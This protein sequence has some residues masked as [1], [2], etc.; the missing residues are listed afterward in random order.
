MVVRE[1]KYRIR[2][3]L[4]IDEWG[5]VKKGDI[6]TYYFNLLDESNGLARF[7]IDK[8]WEILSCDEFTGLIDIN[9][10]DVYTGDIIKSTHY[11]HHEK[12]LILFQ[13]VIFGESGYEAKCLVNREDLAFETT[14]QHC[15]LYWV[16]KIEV[17]DNIY[18][19]KLN[20]IEV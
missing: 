16:D 1:L 7:S 6:K 8:H 17:I 14:F 10:E 4:R 2:L 13:K 5:S 20:L 12:K 9:D 11:K 19:N 18:E 3:K 15:P